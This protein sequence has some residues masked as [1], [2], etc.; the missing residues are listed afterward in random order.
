MVIVIFLI[1]ALFFVSFAHHKKAQANIVAFTGCTVGGALA[2]YIVET[3]DGL[4]TSLNKYAKEKLEKLLPNIPGLNNRIRVIGSVPVED[5][6]TKGSVDA[7]STSTKT[8]EQ[9]GDVVARCGAREILST[10]S[11]RFADI[12]RNGGKDGGTLFVRNWRNYITDSQYQG[13]SMTRAMLSTAN[14]CDYMSADVKES[15]HATKKINLPGENTRTGGSES[16]ALK[17]N[18]TLPAGFN[19]EKYLED[20]SA[21]G[22][23]EAL[24]RLLEPQNNPMGLGQI[25]GQEIAKQSALQK[26]A[27]LAEAMAGRGYTGTR[28]TNAQ[29]SCKQKDERGQ[30]VQYNKI[31]T[32][33]SYVAD[34]LAALSSQELSW[35]GNVDEIGELIANAT[36]IMLNRM[37]NL[38]DPNEGNYYV[39][40]KPL[41]NNPGPELPECSI[42]GNF[43]YSGE[44]GS[45]I[46]T[47]KDSDAEYLNHVPTGHG[48]RNHDE[49][50]YEP[51]DLTQAALD[52]VA[53]LRNIMTDFKGG[54]IYTSCSGSGNMATDAI[55]FGKT[56]DPYGAVFD[57]KSGAVEEDGG[58]LREA[59][60][61][62]SEGELTDW[63]RLV[64]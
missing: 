30:C 24:V 46:R 61:Y 36:E 26:E 2:P 19:M 58:T 43:E 23:W 54:Q 10:V 6:P 40:T 45:A 13:E 34:N 49:W 16:F 5:T 1:S 62:S 51:E 20:P 29:D 55:I 57:F 14:V 18:C 17:A 50:G 7:F 32:P 52:L 48:G 28:G 33:G 15:M 4:N 8:K 27:D 37:I 59:L 42:A 11:V 22:G 12:V 41:P 3:L 56:S 47:L 53:I 25:I 31:N 39:D 9:W 21:N 38:S 60:Q 63:I 44:M 64:Q 35:I